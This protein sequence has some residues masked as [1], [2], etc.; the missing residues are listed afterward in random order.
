[1]LLSRF[2]YGILAIALGVSVFILFVAVQM[3]N[4][5]GKVAMSDSLSSDSSSVD[6]FLR[7]DA[8][9]RSSAL[10]NIALSPEVSAGLA[11]AS[12]DAKIDDDTL[13]K[14]TSAL[15]KLGEDSEI[16]RRNVTRAFMV[17]RMVGI[18]TLPLPANST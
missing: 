7:D 13:G 2:W 9:K 16:S 17:R 14:I 11:K 15:R 12:G 18:A 8:R 3:Y 4:R 1:M 5:T 6:W 10:I